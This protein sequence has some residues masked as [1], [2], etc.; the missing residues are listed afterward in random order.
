MEIYLG[1]PRKGTQ[2]NVFDTG[3]RGSRHGNGVPVA[4]QACGYPQD[5]YFRNSRRFWVRATSSSHDENGFPSVRNTERLRRFDA[6]IFGPKLDLGK[7]D[8]LVVDF[9]KRNY[10]EGLSIC[11]Q[12]DEVMGTVC[13]EL[14]RF[15]GLAL[16]LTRHFV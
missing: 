7:A 16:S 2:D 5:V 3:L 14:I 15:V 6:I 1:N 13:G 9:A 8:R 11:R 12:L 10:H 4:T